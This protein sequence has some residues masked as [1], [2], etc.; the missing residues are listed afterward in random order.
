M[1][2][3]FPKWESLKNKSRKSGMFF[4]LENHHPKHHDSP[5][6]APQNHHDLPPQNTPKSAKPLEKMHI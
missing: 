3:T 2:N 6:N 4:N 5:R 1:W